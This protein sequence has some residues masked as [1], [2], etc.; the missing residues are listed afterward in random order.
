MV[1]WKNK[2]FMKDG[3]NDQTDQMGNFILAGKVVKNNVFPQIHRLYT[4]RRTHSGIEIEIWRILNL[5][6]FKFIPLKQI[7]YIL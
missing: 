7:A 5:T 4:L 1:G 2:C 3:F 6:F